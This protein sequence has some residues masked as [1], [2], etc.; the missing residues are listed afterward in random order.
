MSDAPHQ[1]QLKEYCTCEFCSYK[2][3]WRC[4]AQ[5]DI[6]AHSRA[7]GLI[8]EHGSHTT[9]KVAFK[10]AGLTRYVSCHASLLCYWSPVILRTLES[11]ENPVDAIWI[12]LEETGERAII[13]WNK[14]VQWCYTGRL[15]DPPHISDPVFGNDGNIEALWNAAVSLEMYE[16]AN[17]CFRLIVIKYTWGFGLWDNEDSR[18]VHS[19]LDHRNCPWDPVGV[20]DVFKN[21]KRGRS[22]GRLFNFIEDMIYCKG[23]LGDTLKVMDRSTRDKWDHLLQSDRDFYEWI[24]HGC[25]IDLN[26]NEAI[27][28]IHYNQWDRYIIKP[29]L[30]ISDTKAWARSNVRIVERQGR[31]LILKGA[32]KESSSLTRVGDI[33]QFYIK[34]EAS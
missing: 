22:F 9:I 7:I 26:L 15:A 34:E 2:Q 20:H 12:D 11:I 4:D 30:K 25:P 10:V 24:K 1:S 16:L 5:R 27:L 19:R 23:P 8:L 32:W 31:P 18:D 21:N 6:D 17:F 13:I 14:I 33:W 29:V 28:P 3:K